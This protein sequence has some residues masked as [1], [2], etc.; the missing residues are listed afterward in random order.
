MRAREFRRPEADACND[1]GPIPLLA[2]RS[3]PRSVLTV[4]G[5]VCGSVSLSYVASGCMLITGSAK[6]RTA[7]AA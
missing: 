4:A 2:A 7:I 5:H 1:N 3:A 6:L